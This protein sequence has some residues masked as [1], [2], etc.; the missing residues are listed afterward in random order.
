MVTHVE[1][2]VEEPSMEAALR[3][4]VP[5]I[6]GDLSFEVYPHQCKHDL[7]D[8]LPARLRGYAAW[9]PQDWRIMV[10]VDRDDDHCNQLKQGLEKVAEQARLRTRTKGRGRR[11]QVVNRLAIEELEA[12]FFGDWEAVRAAYPSVNANIPAK[13]GYRDPDAIAGGT[14]EALERTLQRAGYFRT[15]LRKIEAARTIAQR[16]EPQ[17]NRSTSF[18]IF[19]GALTDM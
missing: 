8:K 6:V 11:I 16:M 4:V 19:R 17:R 14:W 2:L 13:Q 18:Q 9:L 12:W 1:I 3:L 5:K 15:G 10:I 7:L